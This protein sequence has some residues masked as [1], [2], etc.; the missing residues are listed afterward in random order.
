MDNP[1]LVYDPEQ[2]RIE[3][4]I[5]ANP[6]P[7]TFPLTRYSLQADE[8][9][10]KTLSTVGDFYCY[11]WFQP[12]QWDLDRDNGEYKI[13]IRGNETTSRNLADEDGGVIQKFV[14]HT[15]KIVFIDCFFRKTE[16][17]Y[18]SNRDLRDCARWISTV[19]GRYNGNRDKIF[20]LDEDDDTL[21]RVNIDSESLSMSVTESVTSIAREYPRTQMMHGETFNELP[22]DVRNTIS[23]GSIE[24]NPDDFFDPSELSSHTLAV[25]WDRLFQSGS[26][27]FSKLEEKFNGDKSNT[28]LSEFYRGGNK[29]LDILAHLNEVPTSGTIK[30]SDMRN[31]TNKLIY[32]IQ[33]N[34]NTVIMRWQIV[35]D[36]TV[37]KSYITKKVRVSGRLGTNG[38][39]GRAFRWNQDMG[40]R[41]EM[42]VS[43]KIYGW[44]GEKGAGNGGNGGNGGP[45][46]HFAS[47]VHVKSGA[48]GSDAAGGGGGG[49]GGGKGGKGG[50]GGH[51]GVKRCAGYF[52]WGS[53]TKCEKNGGEG[54]EPGN[55]GA[56]GYG[57]GFRWN[58]SAWYIPGQGGQGG[59]RGAGGSR[60][61]GGKGGNGGNGGNGGTWNVSGG[62]GG[63]GEK[64]QNGERDEKGCGYRGDRNGRDGRSGGSAGRA[65]GWATFSSNGALFYD[66]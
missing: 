37:W 11:V 66:L 55:G 38:P 57:K 32:D 47:P 23:S 45:A 34:G 16:T 22:E 64:G 39:S 65:Q 20:I 25:T 8:Q 36:E 61:G 29:I 60:R 56:G 4:E 24:S 1:K 35:A 27:K 46:A 43:G 33:G 12:S 41:G 49:A 53:K 52:C 15:C 14:S 62:N 44:A 2:Q 58:G 31:T 28:K 40:G 9:V 51:R 17:P 21:H 3:D 48:F 54:G 10:Y 30:A 5:D 42:V 50:G 13:V 6:Q 26:I 7:S 59:Q 19:A 63:N 18:K